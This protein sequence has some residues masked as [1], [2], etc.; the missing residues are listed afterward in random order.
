ME[1]AKNKIN[2]TYQVYR[3]L[4]DEDKVVAEVKK[5]QDLTKI[6]GFCETLCYRNINKG[7][8]N[9]DGKHYR[10]EVI[11][12]PILLVD[13]DE[14]KSFDS[15]KEVSHEYLNNR[16]RKLYDRLSSGTNT[17]MG[18]GSDPITIKQFGKEYNWFHVEQTYSK[19]EVTRVKRYGTVDLNANDRHKKSKRNMPER[20]P[21]QPDRASEEDRQK[22]RELLKEM[23]KYPN[24]MELDE[25]CE[26]FVQ[27]RSLLSYEE[28][29]DEDGELVGE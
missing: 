17:F 11:K 16:N 28:D 15:I 26:L 10:V 24:L 22:Q 2:V 12:Y 14:L 3:I 5:K 27:F 21:G 25:N 19:N 7:S 23:E 13:N 6:F 29:D 20:L 1:K 18:H 4:D 9:H 8:F